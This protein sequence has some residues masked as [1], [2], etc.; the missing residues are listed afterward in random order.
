MSSNEKKMKKN[1]N[2][3]LEFEKPL[4]S[5]LEKIDELE[6]S[7][8]EGCEDVIERL[9]KE[10]K[11]LKERIYTNLQPHQRLQIA[12]H[13]DRPYSLDYVKELGTNW[14]ELHGDRSGSDDGAIV[15]GL[16]E[17]TE[18]Q[19]VVVVGNEK[20]RGIKEKQKRNFGM[21]Q[22]W[23]YEK[24][25]R[26]FKHAETFNLP[27]ITL[28]D[29]PGAYPGL[30]AEAKGQSIAIARSIQLMSTLK[31]PIIAVI[32]G[33]GGSGGALALG[34]A[35]RVLML[36]HSVYSVISP[37]GCAAILWRTREKSSEAATALRIT[38]K[39]LLDLGLIDEIIT[40]PSGGAHKNYQSSATNIKESILR[41]LNQLKG[42]SL[43]ELQE[44]RMKK[45]RHFG[46]FIG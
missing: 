19:T 42:F 18:G 35:N 40:E 5:L 45:F 15:G 8:V 2:F 7:N 44:D 17:L 1:S 26:L 38:A 16:L 6:E 29:T 22:P 4:G 20:G 37:E 9:K 34:V 27:I 30:E 11:E 31:V 36:E 43:E 12:R 39:E 32:T 46:A 14:I 23:G 41:H 13:P 21:P 24:A 3:V 10:F 28:I 25:M 33:E